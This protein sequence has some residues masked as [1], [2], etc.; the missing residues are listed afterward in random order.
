MKEAAKMKQLTKAKIINWH[1]F[2]NETIPVKPLVFLTGLN[3]SGKSTIIDALQVVLLGDTLGKFFNK[4]A[5]DKSARTL[6]GYLRGEL[7]DSTDGTTRYLRPGRFTSY[8][9]LEFFDD[10]H[11]NSFVLGIVFDSYETGD[12]EHSFFFLDGPMPENEFIRDNVPLNKKDLSEFLAKEYKHDHKFFQSNVSY[13]DF[14]KAQLGGLKDKYFALLKKAT[15]FTPI[16]DITKFITEFIC[17]PQEN[18]NL[19]SLQSNILE[20][21]KLEEEAKKLQIRVDLLDRISETY[22]VYMDHLHT[23]NIGKYILEKCQIEECKENIDKLH[24]K[25]AKDESRLKE[26]DSEIASN[27]TKINNCNTQKIK[28]LADKSGDSAASLINDLNNQKA[29]LEADIARLESQ[30][31]HVKSNLRSLCDSYLNAISELETNIKSFDLNQLGEDS[32]E[33]I[34][35]LQEACKTFSDQCMDFKMSYVD[36]LSKL[37]HEI[38]DQFRTQ[39]NDFKA[40]VSGLSVSLSKNIKNLNAKISSLRDEQ[41]SISAGKKTYPANYERIR[42]YIQNQLSNKHKTDVSVNFLCDLIDIKD[43]SWTDAIEGYLNVNRFYLFVENKYF[44]EAFEQL[45]QYIKLNGYT[46]VAIVDTERIISHNPQAEVGSLADEIQTTH[47]GARAFVNFLIGKLYKCKDEVEARDKGRGITK[48]C[49]LYLN[50]TLTT[51][52]PRLYEI[53]Y[54]GTAVSKRGVED[55]EKQLKANLENLTTYNRLN[56]LISK[57]NNLETISAN[58]VE[59]NLIFIQDT[60]ILDELRGSLKTIDEQ[61]NAKGTKALDSIDLRISDIDKEIAAFNEKIDT[62]NVEK[63]NLQNEVQVIEFEKITAENEKI[64]N[65]QERLAGAYEANLIEEANTIYE[66]LR[67]QGRRSKDILAEFS[68]ETSKFNYILSDTKRQ[69]IKDRKTYCLEYHLSYDT[70]G[71]DNTYYDNDLKEFKENQL[72]RYKEKI[73]DSY[74]KATQQFKEEFISKLRSAIEEVEDQMENLNEALKDC[75]FG[76]DSYRFTVN[77]SVVYRRYYDMIKDD[78]LLENNESFVEKYKEVMDDLFKQIIDV[79]DSKKNSQL[80]QNVEKYT[81]YRNYLDFDIIVYNKETGN[82]TKLSTKMKT[83]S[84]GETQTPFYIAVLASFA[85]LYH[86]ND[87]GELGNTSRII[88]FDEAFSKMDRSR[89]Q[90]SVRLLRDFDLQVIVSAPSDKVGDISQLVDETLVVLRSS[91]SSSVKL[92]AEDKLN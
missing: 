10:L 81:D 89:I 46:N 40:I 21:K 42:D 25:I 51:I 78:I 9:A 77:P 44:H 31:S 73:E 2:W 65:I 48:D 84:G 39:L 26:I 47:D 5:M 76:K 68:K 38:Y 92:F 41:E 85:Q 27:R 4:A 45:K 86:V 69:L 66:D 23:Y 62:L 22:A 20:Y 6:K 56:N 60:A 11:S 90:Q 72:P 53:S 30:E 35:D 8:V 19:E 82:E 87:K 52:N 16:T 24:D 83:N 13:R 32:I 18:I 49:S 54:I 14:L 12:E 17:D 75:T 15:S 91:H 36:N 50:F 70:E 74:N 64:K 43:T 79:G 7:G 67:N 71:D 28:L 29:A 33:D 80:L 57:V 55:R 61:L 59:T 3:G 34:K 37:T 1:Y 88:I 58:E 63:G